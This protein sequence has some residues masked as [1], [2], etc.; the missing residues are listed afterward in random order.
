MDTADE[1]CQIRSES[2]IAKYQTIKT[3]SESRLDYRVELW[4]A[5]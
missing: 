5:E 3:G 1:R 4:R 2:K